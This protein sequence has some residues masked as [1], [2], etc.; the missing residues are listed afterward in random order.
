MSKLIRSRL[1]SSPLFDSRGHNLRGG[2][3]RVLVLII[4]FGLAQLWEVHSATAQD[5]VKIL[6]AMK[7]V[8]E[9][10]QLVGQGKTKSIHQGI[11]KYQVAWTIFKDAGV[12]PGEVGTLVAIGMAY[13]TLEEWGN[14][15]TYFDR[16]LALARA[17]P[18]Q[19]QHFEAMALTGMALTQTKSHQYAKAVEA[20]EEARKLLQGE[21][22]KYDRSLKSKLLTGLGLNYVYMGEQQKGFDYLNEALALTRNVPDAEGEASILIA[23]GATYSQVGRK[24]K[25]LE[26][27]NQALKIYQSLHNKKLEAAGLGLFGSVYRDMGEY[28]K[29]LGYFERALAY[30]RE[31]EDRQHE[32]VIFLEIGSVYAHM[33]DTLKA[34]DYVHQ[35]LNIRRA[36]AAL[37]NLGQLYSSIGEFQKALFYYQEALA[38]EQAEYNRRGEAATL[39]N[40][41]TFYFELGDLLKASEYYNR[42]LPLMQAMND[43]SGEADIRS[44]LGGVSLTFGQ[45]QQALDHFNRALQLYRNSSNRSGEVRELINIG[46]IYAGQN[47]EKALDYYNQALRFALET[48][49]RIALATLFNNTGDIHRKQAEHEKA[50]VFYS[51]ALDIVRAAGDRAKEAST[52]GNIAISQRAL[53]NLPQARAGIESALNILESL[54]TKV[55]SQELRVSYFAGVQG[56]FEFNTDLLM[57]LHKLRPGEG[58]DAL[59]LQNS[60][61]ARARSLLDSLV[62]ARADI[63]QG[64]DAQ[65]LE[66]E[67][68]LQQQLDAN[69]LSQLQL[70]AIPNTDAQALLLSKEINRV[71]D[72]LQ[73]VRMEIK[74]TSPHYAALT[75]PQP[76]TLKEIQTEVLDEETLMLEFSLGREKSHLW[77]VTTDSITSYELPKRA[78][79]E[80]TARLAY[81]LFLDSNRWSKQTSCPEGLTQ[82]S[83]MLLSQVA[84]RLGKKRLVIIS[85]GVL[86]YIPFGALPIPT[87]ADKQNVY[88][89]LITEHEII[90]LPSA[91]TL[92]VLRREMRDR[93]PAERSLFVLADPVF[94]S[95]DARIKKRGETKTT[96][97]SERPTDPGRIQDILSPLERAARETL[98]RDA[99]L[100][101]TRLPLSRIEANQISDII[102]AAE[103][104]V[105]LD[106]DASRATAMSAAL[107]SYRYVHF[108]THGFLNNLHPELSG[109]AL[110]MFDEQGRPEDGFLRAHQ[111]FNLKLNAD[112][113]VLSACRTGMGEHIRG[114]GLIGLT[115]GFMYAGSPRVLVSLW[116]VTDNATAELMTRFYKEMVKNKQRP[117]KAL[118][119]AQISMLKEARYRAP[120][121]W[122]AFIMQGEWR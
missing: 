122:A 5:P 84:A 111:I 52:L 107:G 85:D 17:R 50:L 99:D 40:I 22:D 95:N 98:F 39:A 41:G 26:Y 53:G 20:Y 32:S 71:M 116:S 36:S 80:K 38:L 46:A 93:K 67:R 4:L 19:D 27:Y 16:A 12:T 106:F 69:A 60:E 35:S 43:P 30:I 7:A 24:Q 94:E 11:E 28:R 70:R 87:T 49:D 33:G 51:R 58:F 8:K 109:L 3:L 55:S 88:V 48:E 42:A 81:D 75:Q 117:S 108:A 1:A 34:I 29:A 119:E 104:K 72:E 105:A 62:E 86:Q 64:V 103:R 78:E 57:S 37:N 92:A 44:R 102:P 76:L 54:R 110:S 45:T 61:R 112:L 97:K 23:I 15:M 10:Q 13:S 47:N 56:Y 118:Q 73:K 66:R 21:G 89:P 91:S 63:R 25:T 31:V 114:E 9:A 59:A 96:A 68:S 90:S 100:N 120:L 6:E 115:R 65:L 77:A 82:L 113:V 74:Q 101:L 2:L 83:R 14:A 18:M 121:F 79:I